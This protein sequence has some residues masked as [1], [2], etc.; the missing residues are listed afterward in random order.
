MAFVMALSYPRHL[1]VRF[2]LG[3][4]MT[5]FV[6][7]HVQAYTFFNGVARVTLYDNLRSAVLERVDTANR[8]HP[9]LLLPTPACGRGT[10]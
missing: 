9:T 7:G 8:F 4:A 5:Q 1:F 10:R 6:D 3:A 2:Y